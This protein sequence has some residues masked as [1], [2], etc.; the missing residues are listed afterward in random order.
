MLRKGVYRERSIVKGVK[1][2]LYH[3]VEPAGDPRGELPNLT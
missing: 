1:A 3:L 2:E